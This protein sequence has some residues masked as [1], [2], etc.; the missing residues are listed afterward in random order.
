MIRDLFG[1]GHHARR[2]VHQ[3]IRQMTIKNYIIVIIGSLKDI[4]L[5][6]KN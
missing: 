4:K 2:Q 3:I 1:R 6:M 5:V